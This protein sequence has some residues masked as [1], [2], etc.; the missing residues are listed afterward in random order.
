MSVEDTEQ[1]PTPDEFLFSKGLE[2]MDYYV[3][4]T[5]FGEIV[6]LVH[7]DGREFDLL[8]SN[9]ELFDAVIARLLGLGVRVIEEQ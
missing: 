3:R 7:R 1:I 5:P 2:L 8:I 6:G 9:D 4:R